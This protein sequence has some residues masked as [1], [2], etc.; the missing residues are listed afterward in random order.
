MYFAARVPVSSGTQYTL[1]YQNTL[2]LSI[3]YVVLMSLSGSITIVSN[4]PISIPTLPKQ[5]SSLFAPPAE[6]DLSLVAPPAVMESSTFQAI[7]PDVTREL[8]KV[9]ESF[10][11]SASDIAYV[12]YSSHSYKLISFKNVI[13]TVARSQSD[14]RY[15]LASVEDIG[16]KVSKRPVDYSSQQYYQVFADVLKGLAVGKQ[17]KSVTGFSYR[18]KFNYLSFF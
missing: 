8:I 14:S 5:V 1:V 12:F 6:I 17:F 7:Q 2:S 9:I 4:R 11:V 16:M 10:Q 13:Y 15:S 3:L 18:Y